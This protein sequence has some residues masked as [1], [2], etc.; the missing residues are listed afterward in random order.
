MSTGNPFASV[1]AQD[2]MEPFPG[3]IV[4]GAEQTE[5]VAALERAGVPVQP[6][7]DRDGRLTG[8]ADGGEGIVAPETIA[9]TASFPEIY[10]AFSSRGCSLL[11]V[12]ADDRPLGYLTCDGFL[13]MIDPID[14]D[15][16]AGSSKLSDELAY[17]AVPA[18][19][20]EARSVEAV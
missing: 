13:S 11:V 4:P 16:Y 9:H 3:V 15:T 17:L 12:T 1:V 20:G 6:Y 2:I 5:L 7:V 10:E 14:S 18:V 8:V 19:F